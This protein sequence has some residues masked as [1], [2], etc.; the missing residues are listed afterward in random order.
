MVRVVPDK[1]F[2]PGKKVIFTLTK[3]VQKYEICKA[4]DNLRRRHFLLNSGQVI[5]I[6][7]SSVQEYRWICRSP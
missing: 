5:W 6:I 7:N 4:N 1:L 3:N 2:W